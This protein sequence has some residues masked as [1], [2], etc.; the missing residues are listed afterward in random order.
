M[1]LRPASARWFEVLTAR[2]L[3]EPALRALA[4]TGAVELEAHGAASATALLPQL[5]AAVDQYH[6]LAETYRPYWPAPAHPLKPPER[7][8]ETVPREALAHL[9]AWVAAANPVVTELQQGASTQ[10]ELTEL[11]SVLT[12]P[13]MPD[14][15]LLDQ[16]GGALSGRIYHL[17]LGS[18]LPELPAEVLTAQLV[19]ESGQRYLLALGEEKDIAPLDEILAAHRARRLRP[20]PGLPAGRAECVNEIA[21]RQAALAADAKRLH[22]QLDELARTHQLPVALAD[23]HFAEWLVAHVPEM[24][25]TEHFGWITGWTSASSPEPLDAA[26]NRAKV[27]HVLRFPAAPKDINRPVV[28]RNPRWA[29]PFELFERLLGTPAASEADPSMILAVMVPLMFGFMFG[30]VGQ[31]AVLLVAG[32]LLRRRFPAV[33]LLIPCGIAAMVFGVLFGTVFTREDL[34]DALW[35]RPLQHP[36]VPLMVSLS[37]GALVIVLGLL[38]DALQH[39]WAGQLGVWWRTRAGLLLAY[40]GFLGC[41]FDIR[42]L[43]AVA[44]GLV[45]FWVGSSTV[46]ASAGGRAK[47]GDA[48][49]ESIETLLQLLVNT[50]SFVRVGAFALAHAGLAAAIQAI[51]GGVHSWLAAF[52]LVLAGNLAIIVIEGLIV[53]IQ[54]TRLVLFEFFIRFLHGAGR[55]FR[56]LP[57]PEAPVSPAGP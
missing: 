9:N 39:Y 49:G 32:L 48:I 21:T 24:A 2:E 31:G 47:W 19:P 22:A 46:P 3:L 30:D 37:F 14:L 52:I 57:P 1:P 45:W 18:A 40:L 25:V 13:A 44:L 6:G 50:L 5:S 42:S 4:D 17:D 10:R 56:P 41:V 33:A 35:L 15:R 34:I 38:L 16:P 28:L 23:L 43:A 7:E 12:S 54:T 29:R 27:P 36:L 11:A 8:L 51:A 26:L 55:P 20:P 53:G